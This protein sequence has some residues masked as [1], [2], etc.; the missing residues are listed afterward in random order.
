MPQQDQ[1]AGELDHAK[2]VGCVV[3]PT[4]DHAAIVMQ[5]SKQTLDVTA[6]PVTPQRASVLRRGPAATQVVRRDQ[7]HAVLLAP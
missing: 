6:A 7:F 4:G 2:E 5:P 3:L 1:D